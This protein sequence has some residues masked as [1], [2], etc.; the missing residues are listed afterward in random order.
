MRLGVVLHSHRHFAMS[1][2][3]RTDTGVWLVELQSMTGIG[4]VAQQLPTMKLVAAE[5]ELLHAADVCIAG[6][7]NS[8]RMLHT[9]KFM[10][11]A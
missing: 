5:D 6:R 7:Q 3:N 4:N 10:R 8:Y 1:E 9:S 11:I 2:G